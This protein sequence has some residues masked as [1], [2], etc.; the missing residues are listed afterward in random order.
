MERLYRVSINKLNRK[1]R[2]AN[3]IEPMPKR[4]LQDIIK[5]FKSKGGV[6]KID[7]ESEKFLKSQN[8]EAVTLNEN[9]ILLTKNPGRSAVYEE[10]IHARQ[11]R[12]GKNDGSYESRLI[13]EIEA[14]KELIKRKDEL[15][16]TDLEDKQTRLALK[17]YEAEYKK[18]KEHS[19]RR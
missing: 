9:T 12:E 19:K 1:S 4:Q 5:E 2:S 18:F 10:L 3:Y 13:C 17:A 6:I 15:Q 11:F 16:I 7:D 14:Q 8:S